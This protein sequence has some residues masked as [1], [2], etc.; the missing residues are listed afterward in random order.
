VILY[1]ESGGASAHL[2][3]VLRGERTPAHIH[4]AID[5]IRSSNAIE[6][7]IAETRSYIDRTAKALAALPECQE[8][9]ILYNLAR[10][11]VDPH[12]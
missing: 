11:I 2:D 10:C 9:Q 5:A 8:R 12:S 4:H 7:A 1:L 6:S 3:A